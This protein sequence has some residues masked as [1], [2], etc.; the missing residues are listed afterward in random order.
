M[1]LWPIAFGVGGAAVA[2]GALAVPAARR[3]VFGSVAQD[4][5]G[6]ELELDHIDPDTFT[7]RLKSG[8]VM[9]CYRLAGAAYDTKPE[10]EQSAMHQLR[11]DFVHL[12]MAQKTV[13]RSFGVKRQKSTIF[14]ATWPSAALTEIG[15]AEAARFRDAYQV[16]WV[17]T[18]TA[19]SLLALEQVDEK[20]FSM[21]AA[22]KPE[23]LA[24]PADPAL[25]CPLTG[26]LNFLACGDWRDDL[27]AA[28]ANI[29]ANLP[30]ADLAFDRRSVTGAFIAH[31]ARPK[32][33]RIF[34]I[35]EWPDLVSGHLMH[36]IMALAGDIEVYGVAVPVNQDFAKTLLKRETQNPFA[37][38]AARDECAA[39]V[40]L[41][42]EGGTSQVPT[43]MGIILRADDDHG[44]NDLSARIAAILADRRVVYSVE[45]RLAPV[46]WMNRLPDQDKLGRPLKL[47]SENFAA[48]WP[49][50]N[51]PA[52]LASSAFGRAP[53]RS[54]MTGSG[55]NYAFQFQCTDKKQALGHFLVFAPA[56]SGKSSLIM[57]LLSGLAKF[58]GVRSYIFDSKEGTRF[59]V[60]TMGGLYQSYDRLALNPLDTVDSP[61]ARQRITVLVR[62]MLGDAAA[63]DD[64]DTIINHLIGNAFLLPVEDRT[65]NAVAPLSFPRDSAARK[66]FAQW[67]TDPK[68]R[69]GLYAGV[70]NARRD[71]LSALLDQAWMTGINMNEALEDPALGA[72]VVA[73]ISTAIEHMARQAHATGQGR[74]FAVFIDE[75]A[76]LLRNPAFRDLTGVMYREYRKLDGIVGMAFQDPG[77]L[78]A[79]GIADAAIENTSCL[80]FYPNPQG[81]PEAYQRF[82]LNDEQMNFIFSAPE[83]RKVLLVKR[84]A[85]TGFDESLIM[86]VD[87][88]PMGRPLRYFRS[89]PEAVADL[90]K[91]QAKWGDAWPA[92]I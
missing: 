26:F 76:N 42:T 5:L 21:L 47:Y 11:A 37:S 61:V 31:L 70:M 62:L 74:G 10:Q 8:S 25:P 15:E 3:F 77:A 29:S 7:V 73:H 18:L 24:R 69:A 88:A 30:A 63:D 75:A 86:D 16:R 40:Q 57:H 22:Y 90:Q 28:S 67:V 46:I 44:L 14:P 6:H 84:E 56:G 12:C 54:F 53:V 52:G 68:G 59:M 78:H 35:R 33:H 80:F 34:A 71:S 2:A 58:Q 82:N 50:E 17:I 43:Q 87:L 66:A 19:P 4:W 65:F 79:S 83:G 36:D 38:D 91:I 51:A 85:A 27:P 23:R 64:A 45:T 39:G 13:L 9:R 48:L 1:S 20:V 89:G 60:E 72:V 49:F 55:Q 41:L 32:H 92:H 81:K